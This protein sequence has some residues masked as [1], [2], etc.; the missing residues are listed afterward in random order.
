MIKIPANERLI[1]ALDVE[2]VD[3]AQNLIRQMG[4]SVSF[5]KIGMELVYAGGL[6]F[7]KLLAGEGK[8]VFLDLKLHDIPTT[9]ERATARIA[10]LGATFLTVHGFPQTMKAAVLGKAGRDL[11][12]LAVTVMT[13]YDDSD[14]KDAGYSCSVQD[15]V[16]KRAVQAVEAGVDGLIL[17]PWEVAE[18]RALVGPTLE[19]ITPGIRPAGSQVGDQ[20]R[21]MTPREAIKAGADR[22]VIGRPIT[23][24]NDPKLEAMKILAEIHEAAG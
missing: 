8:K 2:T 13:S 3:K 18:I 20:K 24:A 22:L 19:L 23:A 16:R 9:V 1:V 10:E 6:E 7:V 12:I 11:N 4:D 17:S 21:I 15:L 14:L 5:Y